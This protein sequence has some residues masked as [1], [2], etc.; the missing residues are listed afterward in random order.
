MWPPLDTV[1]LSV[2]LGKC[3]DK[4]DEWNINTKVNMAILELTRKGGG[5]THINL[6]FSCNSYN[7]K[8]LPATRVIRRY[9]MG[10]NLPDLPEGRIASFL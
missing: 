1:R 8:E 5:P 6:T 10:D 3:K 2:D 7:T 4:N 9:S